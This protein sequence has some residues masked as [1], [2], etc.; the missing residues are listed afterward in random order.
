MT[1]RTTLSGAYAEKATLP[2][3]ATITD[4]D[5]VTPLASANSVLLTLTLT[6]YEARSGTVI[7]SCTARDIL[8]A[9]GG[10]VSSAGALSIRLDAADMACLRTTESELHVALIEW[11]WGSPLKTGRHEI[12]FVVKNLAFVPAS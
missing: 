6:L 7:N 8:N 5:G 10:T 1:T 2:L 11:T 4:T 12:A 9:N 3:T